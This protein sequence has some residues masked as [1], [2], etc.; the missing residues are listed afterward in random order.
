MLR[1]IFLTV[2]PLPDLPLLLLF[3]TAKKLIKGLIYT[4]SPARASD[5]IFC[6]SSD[7]H[8]HQIVSSVL[9]AV[10]KLIS[11]A[12]ETVSPFSRNGTYFA[13]SCNKMVEAYQDTSYAKVRADVVVNGL[14]PARS[15]QAFLCFPSNRDHPVGARWRSPVR[16]SASS[17]DQ[18][19]F[20]FPVK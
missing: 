8:P 6:A 14:P 11:T 18:S 5:L 15:C 4:S 17:Y 10:H 13:L 20:P 2:W 9:A 16:G 1:T 7:K 19:F 12:A 3:C